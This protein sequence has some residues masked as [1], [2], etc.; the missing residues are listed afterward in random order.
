[1]TYLLDTEANVGTTLHIHNTLIQRNPIF[2]I[3]IQ[4]IPLISSNNT[5]IN[6]VSQYTRGFAHRQHTFRP[7]LVSA[8]SQE[9]EEH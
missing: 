4:D 3:T 8:E 7:C 6:A 9:S 2:N 5:Q 1:M